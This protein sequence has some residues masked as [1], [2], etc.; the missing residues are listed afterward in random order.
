VVRNEQK[1]DTA[2]R[3]SVPVLNY[4]TE[5]R[6]AF[7][8]AMILEATEL[9]KCGDNTESPGTE[10]QPRGSPNR[11]MQSQVQ[12][13]GRHAERQPYQTTFSLNVQ[14]ESDLSHCLIA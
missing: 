13:M 6:T 11:L 10:R 7:V 1:S 2:R 4:G 14:V 3:S 12:G 9:E 5:R 8:Q